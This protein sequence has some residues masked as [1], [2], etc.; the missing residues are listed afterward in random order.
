MSLQG[1]RRLSMARVRH[2]A[3]V[4]GVF[5]LSLA[6]PVGAGAAEDPWEADPLGLIA[7]QD[8]VSARYTS[9]L[10][11]WEVWVCEVSDGTVPVDVPVTVD[12]LNDQVGPFFL[13][14][15]GGI[16]QPAFRVGGVVESPDPEPP[17]GLEDWILRDC[18]RR[19]ADATKG[20]AAGVLIVANTNFFGG[21]A[22]MGFICPGFSPGEPVWCPTTYPD[23]LRRA[24]V[25]AGTVITTPPLVKPRISAVAHEIG[26][27]IGWPHSFS[28]VTVDETGLVSQYDNPMDLMSGGGWIDLQGNTLAINRYAAGWVAPTSVT[29]HRKG[30]FDYQIG[31]LGTSAPQLLVL[32]TDLGPS[33]YQFIGARVPQGYDVALPAQGVE[34]YEVNQTSSVCERFPWEVPDWPCYGLARRT[35][36]LPAVPG[37]SVS[38]VHPVGSTFYVRNLTIQVVEQVDGVYTLRVSG[39]AVTQ[40]FVDDNDNQHEA[41]IE[42]IAAA[43]ITFGCNPPLNDRYCPTKPVSRAEMAAFLLR[44]IDQTEPPPPYLGA[45]SDVPPGRWYTSYVEQLYQLRLT[46]GYGDGTYGPADPVARSQM[47]AFLLRALGQEANLT[48]VRGIF[49]DV[50]LDAWYAPYVERLYDLG[51]TTGCRTD[52]L[53]Y[54]PGHPVTRDQMGAFLAR[55]LTLG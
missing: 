25:G 7:F 47:A 12:L 51:I 29:F 48:A 1:P 16:Y 39:D 54:C 42:A 34:V 24:V 28:G 2:A 10:D 44:L 37:D 3:L 18:E 35:S 14:L 21:Y 11:V 4:T 20:D 43:G 31:A 53:A 22:D 5:V 38:H 32:P 52:P 41:D 27:A 15:S 30:D 55:V 36:Q 17:R 50:P 45:F 46:V 6:V 33:A 40:R 19:V 49:T 9:G 23:N 26:H 8:E 13:T